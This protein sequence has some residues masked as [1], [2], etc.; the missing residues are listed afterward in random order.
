MAQEKYILVKHYCKVSK[1]EDSFLDRLHEFGLITFKERQ[2][3]VY[4]DEQDI[5]EIERM[6]RLHHDLGINFEGL[7]AI[8]EMLARIQQL[9]EEMNY[10]QKKLRLYE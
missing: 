7:D 9:E 2:N 8:K 5:S 6:F 3:D 4:I 1:I 10:L